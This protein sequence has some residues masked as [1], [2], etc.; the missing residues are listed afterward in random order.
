[1][2][3][4]TFRDRRTS[5]TIDRNIDLPWQG[6]HPEFWWSQDGNAGCDCNRSL[7]MYDHDPAR[8]VACSSRNLIVIDR[9]T[10]EGA[11]V[12]QDP[13]EVRGDG[14][15]ADRRNALLD[16]CL[17]RL[18][19]VQ[20][21]LV[22]SEYDLA[23]EVRKAR[24]VL[25]TINAA[26]LSAE[27]QAAALALVEAGE[28]IAAAFASPDAVCEP[29]DIETVDQCTQQLVLWVPENLL[30][31]VGTPSPPTGT[32]VDEVIPL[33]MDLHELDPSIPPLEEL[34]EAGHLGGE[35]EEHED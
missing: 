17:R 20:T 32:F 25:V 6:E 24:A 28:R 30:A 34:L 12:Y 22:D 3:K 26:P 33:V 10:H 29:C 15:E 1:M 16:S 13:P 27:V 23:T 19:N 21:A 14:S 35:P 11:V 31:V 5:R 2:I 7:F 8:K 9:I 4:V 18:G